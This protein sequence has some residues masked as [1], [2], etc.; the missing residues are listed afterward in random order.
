VN[1][2]SAV[3]KKNDYVDINDF[4]TKRYVALDNDDKR[5]NIN[6]QP[7][8]SP[9]GDAVIGALYV[10]SNIEQKYSEIN[11]TAVI[12]FTASLIA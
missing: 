8:L 9:T 1:E 2:Q 5:V 10:K 7:I 4:T 12:F 11:N 6:V 3:G